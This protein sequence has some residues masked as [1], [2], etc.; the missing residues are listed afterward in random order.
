LSPLPSATAAGAA[1]DDGPSLSAHFERAFSLT[2]PLAVGRGLGTLNGF[3]SS[4]LSAIVS[5]RADKPGQA[6]QA[7]SD[8]AVG[9]SA[10]SASAASSWSAAGVSADDRTKINIWSSS[11]EPADQSCC[12]SL[13][14]PLIDK[15]AAHRRVE[16][17]SSIVPTPLTAAQAALAQMLAATA[18]TFEHGVAEAVPIGGTHQPLDHHP[19]PA[20][21]ATHSQPSTR[22]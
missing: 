14:L 5:R 7:A 18:V 12:V 16:G 13:M 11:T 8:Q 2:D 10:S 21:S 15:R 17:L 19:G 3:F 4:D 1:A 6:G 9:D 22:C 20:A